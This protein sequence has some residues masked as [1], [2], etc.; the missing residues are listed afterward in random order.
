MLRI[1]VLDVPHGREHVMATPR[2]PFGRVPS[3]ACAR[4][5]DEY[6]SAH[7]GSFPLRGD[8]RWKSLDRKQ[9]VSRRCGIVADLRPGIRPMWRWIHTQLCSRFTSSVKVG[10]VGAS[11]MLDNE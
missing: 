4:T 8:C 5:G 10:R 7:V 6:D 1:A 9:G 2:Q 3:E 11:V